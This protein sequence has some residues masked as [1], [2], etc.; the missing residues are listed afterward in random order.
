M[1]SIDLLRTIAYSIAL[2]FIHSKL[3]IWNVGRIF[4][5]RIL[6]EMMNCVMICAVCV[7]IM[8]ASQIIV[9]V[10]YPTSSFFSALRF[11][12][13]QYNIICIHSGYSHDQ[14]W[15]NRCQLSDDG[16]MYMDESARVHCERLSICSL[17]W[18]KI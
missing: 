9:S 4:H 17:L 6:T 18:G 5:A 1:S 8:Q 15:L 3:A 10:K 13:R 7:D 12:C 2:V 14:E 11:L 16:C